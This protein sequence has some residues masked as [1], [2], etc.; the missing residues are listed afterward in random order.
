MLNYGVHLVVGYL[1]RLLLRGAALSSSPGRER[2]VHLAGAVFF[3]LQK[4]LLA[5]GQASQFLNQKAKSFFFFW[6][7]NAL[8]APARLPGAVDMDRFKNEKTKNKKKKKGEKITKKAR[9]TS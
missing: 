3:T 4:T 9:S 1:V 6:Q 7:N 8:R 5:M 2:E